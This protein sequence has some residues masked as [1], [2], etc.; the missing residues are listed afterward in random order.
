VLSRFGMSDANGA[1]TLMEVSID[2]DDSRKLATNVPY[3]EAI[4]SLMYLMVGTRPD[5]AFAV[6]RMA[7]YVELLKLALNQMAMTC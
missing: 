6:S 1:R 5:I 3:R 2:V 4:G 7:Q